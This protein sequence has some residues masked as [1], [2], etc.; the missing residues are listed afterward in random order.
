MHLIFAS[1]QAAMEALRGAGLKATSQRLAILRSLS[2]DETH[3]TAQEL[4]ERLHAH[5]PTL[6]VATVYNT[7][8][9]LT[10]MQRCRPIEL[11]GPIRF[12]PNV[13]PHDHA[14]CELCGKIRDVAAAPEAER[15]RRR[16]LAGFRVQRVERIY[17][18]RCADCARSAQAARQ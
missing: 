12:D 6:S 9:A 2:G 17:R 14:V 3:P 18:G 8:S 10:R 5:F 13:A 7:L 15:R 11:G 1:D 16:S 4:Y